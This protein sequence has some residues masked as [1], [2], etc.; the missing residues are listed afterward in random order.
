M[1]WTVIFFS[2]NTILFSFL[3][4]I[5][6]LFTMKY[7]EKNKKRLFL[8]VTLFFI[9]GLLSL[10]YFV[11]NYF[12]GHGIDET[13][14]DALNL[15][16]KSAGFEEYFLLMLGALFSFILLFIIAFFYYRHL[17]AVVL[18]KP[19]KIKAFL[20]NGFFLLAFLMHPALGD[21][22]KIYQTS[23][24]EQSDDFYEYYKAPKTSDLRLNTAKHRK[25]IVYIYAES[26][27]RT[28]FDT[29]IF[30]DLTPNLS[31]LI[32]SGNAIEFTNINQ[33]TGSNYT[34]AGLTSTQCGIPLFTT[35]GGDSMEGMDTF[36]Q[37]AICLGDVL[38]KE[39]Y[40]LSFLQGSS[41]KFA[42]MD[43]FFKTHG[44]DNIQGRGELLNTIEHKDYV[45]G[46]GLYDDT[47][48]DLAYDEFQ[49][50][51]ATK[52]QFALM[53]ITL[54][55][56]HPN[57]HL[58]VS[59]SED[60]YLDGSNDILN[61][62]KCSDILISKFIKKIKSSQY[63]KNT[64]IV[65]TSDHLAMRNS[66]IEQINK[67]SNR[68]N[69]F[70]VF[71]PTS[72]K[73]EAIDTLGTPLDIASTVLSFVGIETD[74]GLGRN[75]REK[76]SL[77]S[78][79]EDYD[80][81]LNQWRNNILSFWKFPKMADTIAIDLEKMSVNI[82]SNSYTLPVLFKISDNGIE[83]YF[84]FNNSW[85]LF[86]Q[87]ENFDKKDKFLWIDKCSLMNY[88]FDS[89]SSDMYCVT[90]GIVGGTYK[91]EG[92]YSS[93]THKVDNYSPSFF[94]ANS[95]LETI[96]GNIDML[97]RNGIKYSASIEDKVLFKKEGYPSFLKDI[98]GLSY[99]DE[100]GR[101][102]DANLYPSALF[103]F[104]K[105]L[106]QKFS[107]KIVSGADKNNVGQK[108]KVKIGKKIKTFVPKDVDFHEYTLN[109][110]NVKNTDTIEVIP[111]KTSSLK[112]QLEGS[113]NRRR[114]LLLVSLQITASR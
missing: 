7:K 95:S 24:M 96:L 27:E 105:P 69:L 59:C 109:F 41:I 29:D 63:S 97:K 2:F 33:T 48:L 39:N 66:A 49:T 9:F 54:D 64:L 47:L 75:L 74:L 45:N 14:I 50:L 4:F 6:A 90:E 11:A 86:E 44:F 91:V 70:V 36:Y 32:K 82:A 106:P 98:Q 21:F 80:T 88:I 72:K 31:A 5:F 53:L 34:I 8:D 22:Y 19:K 3:F 35:S 30:P 38:K 55:T 112:K 16:L 81:K 37:E 58:S 108:V 17:H 104:E 20:H 85:Q 92:I 68:R 78:L 60:L 101:W 83:P 25:N 56:H 77:Y 28:Y 111:P 65:V 10:I 62:V 76:D 71:E 18:A 51:S 67:S 40:Y 26:F 110:E 113:D 114:G 15:G 43:K 73:Y 93:G 84:Q 107:L 94:N 52:E 87:L 12:T 23:S 102:S 100:N 99:P 1:G 61:T 13:V 42:G 46:W 89:N 79:F 103:T 57:G